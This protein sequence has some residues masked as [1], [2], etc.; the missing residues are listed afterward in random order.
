MSTGIAKQFFDEL[1][2]D[3]ELGKKFEEL[4]SKCEK[5]TEKMFSDKITE[6]MQKAG[7]KCAE[8]HLRDLIKEEEGLSDA[9]MEKAAGGYWKCPPQYYIEKYKNRKVLSS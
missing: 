8:K 3:R 9:D 1:K 5:E 6:F 2:K 4:L 7:F